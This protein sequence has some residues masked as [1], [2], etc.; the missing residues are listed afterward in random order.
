MKKK[1]GRKEERKSIFEQDATR[2][3]SHFY[4]IQ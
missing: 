2:V 4:S 3:S 1:E